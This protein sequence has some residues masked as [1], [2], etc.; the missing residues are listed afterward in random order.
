MQTR[1]SPIYNYSSILQQLITRS[2]IVVPISQRHRD[3]TPTGRLVA[4][5]AVNELQRLARLRGL[6]TCRAEHVEQ[7]AHNT[8]LLGGPKVRLAKQFDK[9]SAK[10]E[11]TWLG[12]RLSKLVRVRVVAE[13]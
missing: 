1:V 7:R 9:L 13:V 8:R 6:H 12:V 11:R 10:A 3:G 4:V 5:P 2:G